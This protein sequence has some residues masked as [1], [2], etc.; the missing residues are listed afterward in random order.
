VAHEGNAEVTARERADPLDVADRPR[1]VEPRAWRMFARTSAD[2]RSAPNWES[3][4]V[5]ASAR[6]AYTTKLMTMSV[7]IAMR[8]R[9]RMYL[10]TYMSLILGLR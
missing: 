8:R 5:G 4:S 2:P 7:G 10:P 9:L 3:G 1:I 6:I